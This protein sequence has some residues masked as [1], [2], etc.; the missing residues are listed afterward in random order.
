MTGETLRGRAEALRR[1]AG[2]DPDAVAPDEVVELLRYPE[3]RVQRDAAAALLAILTE[4]PEAGTTVVDR[5]AHLLATLESAAPDAESEETRTEFGDTLLFCLARVATHD[6]ERVLSVRDVVVARTDEADDPLA[7]TATVCLVQL[8]EAEPALFVP[9]VDRFASLLGAPAA[10]TR[11][12]AAHLLTVLAERHPATAAGDV[13][14]L[15]ASLDDDDAETVQK[16]ASAIGMLARADADPVV[17]VLPDVIARLDHESRGVRANAAGVVAD[18]AAH[19]PAAV[20]G[21]LGVLCDRLDD[22]PP[23]RRNV[24]AAFARVAAE[25]RVLPAPVDGAL[26]ELL[27]DPDPTVRSLACRA[28]GHAESPA[29]LELLRTAATGDPEG[30]VREAARWAV[31]RIAG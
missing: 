5:L 31:R 16:A 24:A 1:E 13:D 17:E 29:A 6:P 26:I 11:R 22:A 10:P 4:F 9:H 14:A 18:V 19:R 30:Q 3:R 7:P 12:H 28:L 20:A 23:V 25:E 8:V 21:H 15:T 27:D 2:A